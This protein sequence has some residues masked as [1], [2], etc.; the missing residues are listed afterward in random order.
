LNP[1]RIAPRPLLRSTALL[2][3]ALLAAPAVAGWVQVAGENQPRTAELDSLDAG[4]ATLVGDAAGSRGLRAASILMVGFDGDVEP[5]PGDATVVLWSGDELRGVISGGDRAALHLVSRSLGEMKVTLMEVRE[6]R[7][8]GSAERQLG[9]SAA[10]GAEEDVIYLA[11]GDH[12]IGTIDG[13]SQV[14][15]TIDSPAIGGLHTFAF[16]Q[17]DSLV[18]ADLGPRPESRAELRRAIC[19]LTD[20]SRFTAG[21]RSYQQGVLQIVTAAG[22]SLSLRRSSLARLVFLDGDFVWV[23]DLEPLKSSTRSEL[24]FPSTIEY[25]PRMDESVMGGRLAIGGR[26]FA[27][28]IGAHSRSVLA[29]ALPAGGPRTFLATVGIDESVPPDDRLASVVFRVRTAPAGA[30]PSTG[31]IL[32]ESPVVRVS[33]G[34]VEVGP[35]KLAGQEA[36]TLILEVDYADNYHVLDRA[37]WGSARLVP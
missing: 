4:S 14:G 2:G 29:Y 33:S 19:F 37:V 12:T 28:G 17:L 31:R 24:P 32:Y 5:A 9:R 20:G 16:D 36:E 26:V 35:V 7:F 11:S 3:L 6:V 1:A 13:F 23:S 27:K 34:A 30:D 25:P 22:A 10:V 8:P 18:F 15:V 21:V